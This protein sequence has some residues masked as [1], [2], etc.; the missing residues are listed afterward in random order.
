M[1]S[2][3]SS[4]L[5]GSLLAL[6]STVAARPIEERDGLGFFDEVILFDSPAVLSDPPVI[7]IQA[8]TYFRMFDINLGFLPSLLGIDLGEIGDKAGNVAER[9]KLFAS[10]HAARVI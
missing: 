10:V 2:S 5:A 8:Y 1:V 4:F 3:R 9:L 6:A 7:E